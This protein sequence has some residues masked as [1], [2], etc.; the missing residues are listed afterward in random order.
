MGFAVHICVSPSVEVEHQGRRYE[1]EL[2]YCGPWPLKKNGD[3]MAPTT[4]FRVPK[5]AWNLAGAKW[6]E[7]R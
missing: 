6:R 4:A 3:P 1:F 7:R 2:T 5:T